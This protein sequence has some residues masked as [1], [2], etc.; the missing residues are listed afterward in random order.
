[1]SESCTEILLGLF[2]QSKLYIILILQNF[3][4]IEYYGGK[5]AT[6]ENLRCVLC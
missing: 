2:E 3:I 6:K 5:Y 4:N 1:M